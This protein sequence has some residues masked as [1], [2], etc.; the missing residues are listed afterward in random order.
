MLI[1]FVANILAFNPETIQ[2]V[3]VN[4]GN[5]PVSELPT[6][7]Y[8]SQSGRIIS[9]WGAYSSSAYLRV[10]DEDLNFLTEILDANDSVAMVGQS[11]ATV[12]PG[13]GFAVAYQGYTASAINQFRVF[14]RYF[15]SNGLPTGPSKAVTP[16][17]DLL[18]ESQFEPVLCSDGAG[19]VMVVF[20]DRRLGDI[21]IMA[22]LFNPDG[23][24][25]GSNFVVNDGNDT[26][27]IGYPKVDCSDAGAFVV[28][29]HA[30]QYVGSSSDG[31]D[32][33]YRLYA[34]NGVPITGVLTANDSGEELRR[35]EPAIAIADDESYMV[36]AWIEGS[37]DR[38]GVRFC[39]GSGVPLS[40]TVYVQSPDGADETAVS[41]NPNGAAILSWEVGFGQDQRVY[42][43]LFDAAHTPLGTPTSVIDSLRYA[44]NVGLGNSSAFFGYQSDATLLVGKLTDIPTDVE[45]SYYNSIP[46][47]FDLKQ[48]YPNPFN[49][50][51]TISFDLARRQHVRLGI[52]N[53]LGQQVYELVNGELAAGLHHVEWDGNTSRGNR[54]TSGVY[55]YRIVTNDF[56]GSRKMILLK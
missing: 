40:S 48:N 17:G 35:K 27:C 42:Y 31:I 44:P 38:V 32:I 41:I 20:E 53:V 46:N 24:F 29:W 3:T 4:D 15:D 30:N 22:Q 14:L 21:Q 5:S 25:S 12:L 50:S 19:R 51:T 18:S 8:G 1:S 54:A 33:R 6:L 37:M 13:G 49:P 26:C 2:E 9:L 10:M 34:S 16:L 11:D 7:A 45:E 28:T 36:V 39:N 55:F 23:S 52:Y 43:Q 47:A 56:V